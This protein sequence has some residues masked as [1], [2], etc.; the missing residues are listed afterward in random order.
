[1][2]NQRKVLEIFIYILLLCAGLYFTFSDFDDDIFTSRGTRKQETQLEE[3]T[4]PQK[5][6]DYEYEFREVK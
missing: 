2:N 4:V 6:I 5:Y 1:M 3:M